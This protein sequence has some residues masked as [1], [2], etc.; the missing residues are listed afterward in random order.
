[1]STSWASVQASS[2]G[3]FLGVLLLAIPQPVLA[4]PNPC[5]IWE[6]DGKDDSGTTWAATLVLEP[7]DKDEYPP[8][9]LKG[10][11][12]WVGSNKTGGREYV[13]L[14]T[15]DYDT[16][17]LQMRGAELED[18]DPNIRTSIYDVT[19]TE[20]ADRLKDGTWKSCGVIPGVW[21]AKRSLERMPPKKIE[22]SSRVSMPAKT[23]C[24]DGVCPVSP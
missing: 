11:F 12:D 22:R 5:G 13:V 1:M 23:D 8:T 3:A 4:Q 17:T 18:A 20:Q 15:Y 10:Y 6:V 14:A 16:R 7:K 19:M 9:K 21:Q 2:W 24:R